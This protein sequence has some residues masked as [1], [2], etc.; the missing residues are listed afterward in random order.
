M[1]AHEQAKEEI[2]SFDLVFRKPW[3]GFNRKILKIL[4]IVCTWTCHNFLN[5][6]P[7]NVV[8]GLS[9]ATDVSEI[10]ISESRDYTILV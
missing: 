4:G 7:H 6:Q 3:S 8:A 2:I 9:W 10:L 1:G 5:V